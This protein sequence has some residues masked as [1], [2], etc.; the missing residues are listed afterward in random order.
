M[1]LIKGAAL[2][3]STISI[4]KSFVIHALAVNAALISTYLYHTIL[5]EAQFCYLNN[6]FMEVTKENQYLLYKQLS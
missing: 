3:K 6:T 2:L 5:S 1:Y 4:V